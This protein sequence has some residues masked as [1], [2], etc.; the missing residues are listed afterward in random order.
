MPIVRDIQLSLLRKKD[1]INRHENLNTANALVFYEDERFF[2][3]TRC[4]TSLYSRLLPKIERDFEKG[5]LINCVDDMNVL[6]EWEKTQYMLPEYITFFLEFNGEKYFS[7]SSNQEKKEMA[8]N[9]VHSGII[10]IAEQYNW[11]LDELQ[12]V[13]QKIIDLNYNNQYIYKKKTS[14]NKKY[15]CNIICEHEVSYVD[16]CLE[17]RCKKSNML[18]KK[19]RLF[20]ERETYETAFS[21]H[22]GKLFWQMNHKVILMDSLSRDGWRITFLE[23]EDPSKLFWKIEKISNL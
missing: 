23:K 15:I 19:E 17:I 18:I 3:E 11:E 6:S 8:L 2:K 16:I 20:R 9:I 4:I 14:P 21:S 1:S 10:K 13:N 12:E 7:L 5:I 22:I